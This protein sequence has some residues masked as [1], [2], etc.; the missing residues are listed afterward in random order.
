MY[1]NIEAVVRYMSYTA[2]DIDRYGEGD[3]EGDGDRYGDGDV[4][5]E[6][7]VNG[8]RDGRRWRRRWR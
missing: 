7:D 5:R 1:Y 6:R 8:D 3:G 2:S 4:E